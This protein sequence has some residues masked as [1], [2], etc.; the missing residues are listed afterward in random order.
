MKSIIISLCLPLPPA[1]EGVKML[2]FTGDCRDS[3]E[4][5]GDIV[6]FFF[7]MSGASEDDEAPPSLR[8]G[9][10]TGE[11][12]EG[13]QLRPHPVPA[14]ARGRDFSS[15]SPLVRVIRRG[16]LGEGEV[17]TPDHRC[18]LRV[19]FNLQRSPHLSSLLQPR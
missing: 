6:V 3:C 9:W 7:N 8:R 13:W 16:R 19:L 11:K 14:S 2:M 15:N 18:C 5:W 17:I 1:P 12:A 4:I 10:G